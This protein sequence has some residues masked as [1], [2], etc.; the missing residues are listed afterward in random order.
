MSATGLVDERAYDDRGYHDDAGY[1]RCR[2]ALGRDA[3]YVVSSRLVSSLKCCH[4]N[5]PFAN[6]THRAGTR[7]RDIRLAHVIY[8]DAPSV[9]AGS[10]RVSIMRTSKEH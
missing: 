2:M 5:F 1:P 3:K 6:E 9:V 8:G 7:F 4:C 10:A